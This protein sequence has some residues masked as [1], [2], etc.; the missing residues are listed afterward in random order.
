MINKKGQANGTEY[1]FIQESE[2]KRI[3]RESI[4]AFFG[5]LSIIGFIVSFYFLMQMTD[6]LS[7][8]GNVTGIEEGNFY[9]I[10]FVVLFSFI[11]S[12]S[13][14]IWFRKHRKDYHNHRG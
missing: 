9:G 6:N 2:T 4:I 5:T 14:I 11:V 10:I 8:T 12:V 1:K 7:V 3:F 13:A